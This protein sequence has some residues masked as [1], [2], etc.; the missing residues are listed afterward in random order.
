MVYIISRNS[1]FLIDITRLMFYRYIIG[2][3]V[4]GWKERVLIKS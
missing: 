1:V 2:G 4:V 3:L